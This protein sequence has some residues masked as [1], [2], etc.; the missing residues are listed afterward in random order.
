MLELQKELKKFS[1]GAKLTSAVQDV[2]KLIE[3]LVNARESVAAGMPF[4]SRPYSG[5]SAADD[6][7]G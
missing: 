3:L 7:V 4:L 2:D 6:D 1:Q 5:V